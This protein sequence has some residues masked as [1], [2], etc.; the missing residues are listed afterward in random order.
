VW[1]DLCSSTSPT[2]VAGFASIAQL[3]ELIADWVHSQPQGV[4]RLLLGS[5]PFATTR[6][7]FGSASATFTDEAR[8]YWVEETGISLSLSAKVVQTIEAIKGERL[9]VRHIPGQTKLHAKIFVGERAA[10]LG[11]SNFTH[12]G[13]VTQIEA[14]TRFEKATAA[15]DYASVSRIAENYWSQ[16][17]PWTSQLLL[18]LRDLLRFVPWQEAL[19]RAC[20]ELL[21]G[22]W[23]KAYLKEVLGAP[24]WPSQLAGI[25]EALWV[26]E[27]LGSALIADATGSGKTRMGAHLTR[28]VRDRL[29]STGRVRSDLTVL[30][31]PPSVKERWLNEAVSCGPSIRFLKGC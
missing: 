6:L 26:V 21:E 13:L 7:S 16:G 20:A 18:L 23:A 2:V 9:E 29:W 28:A 14:N 4:A 24:L 15:A 8:R 17:E 10:T 3:V 19:A 31:S 5:E 12:A 22:D 30:V 1:Q 11:S 25:A 27:N